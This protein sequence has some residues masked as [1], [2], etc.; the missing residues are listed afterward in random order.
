M[1]NETTPHH[2]ATAENPAQELNLGRWAPALGLLGIIGTVGCSMAMFGAFGED[3]RD[4]MCASWMFG[5]AFWLSMTLGMFGLTLLHHTVRGSW[6]LSIIRLL[7]AGGSWLTLALVAVLYIP[8]L[9][10]MPV[11][12]EWARPE[13]V[14]HDKFLQWKSAFLN[15]SP[16]GF[17][18][19]FLIYFLLWGFISWGLRDSVL[20]QEK[21]GDL[22]LEIGRM[23][24]GAVSICAF[25]I[26]VTLA[27]TDFVMSMEPHWTSTMYGVWQI[28]AGAGAALAF[29]ITILCLNARRKPFNEIVAPNL[30]K[31]LGNMQF[32]MTM[33]WGYTTL[34]QFLIIWNGNLPETTQYFARRSS[35]MHPPGMEANS[36]GALG[37]LLIIGRFFVPFF[38][39][40][41]PRTKKTPENLRRA[42]GW[43]VVMHLFDMYMLVIPAIESRVE[44]GPVTANIALDAIA[45]VSIGALWLAAFAM[46][47]AK[48]PLLA[49]YDRRLQEAKLHAH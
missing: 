21:S 2:E 6:T 18:L 44:L 40:V 34:S 42:T 20:R 26:S 41:T 27:M 4:A 5:W 8:I 14:E 25:M 35:L 13:A 10:N 16:T 39:L 24:W 11:L 19:R 33:L 32:A 49:S 30:L 45:F 23:T 38:W 22:K 1:S 3:A 29:C 37:L 36:W 47:T 12:Y 17:P 9:R 28:V 7:E 48:A 43:I 31:D 46:Q 15:M